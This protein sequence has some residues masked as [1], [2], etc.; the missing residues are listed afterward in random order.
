MVMVY[1]TSTA[2]TPRSSLAVV[3][4]SLMSYLFILYHYVMNS[5]VDLNFMMYP[6]DII[7]TMHVLFEVIALFNGLLVVFYMKIWHVWNALRAR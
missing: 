6:C 4:A 3:V 7:G 1:P 5:Y 2:T